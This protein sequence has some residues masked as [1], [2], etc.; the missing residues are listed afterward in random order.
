[1]FGAAI[2][3]ILHGF[4]LALSLTGKGS[5]FPQP[6][7]KREEQDCFMRMW[8]GDRAARE[9]LIL[10]NMRLVTHIIHKYYTTQSDHE[11]LISIGTIGLVKAVDSYKANKNTAFPTYA[12]TCI[13]NEIFMV[14]RNARKHSVLMFPG[15]TVSAD[16][17]GPNVDVLDM[18]QDPFDVQ[19]ALEKDEDCRRVRELVEARLDERAR[20]IIRLR[21]G[22]GGSAPM[23]QREVAARLNISRSYVSRIEK[24]ALEELGQFM[25]TEDS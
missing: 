19:L 11:D 1:M 18:A 4:A 12:C 25:M 24:R 22:I 8:A 10:H 5:V 7:S 3:L 14:F 20:E 9:K 16:G 13:K 6:L 23:T 15:R 17:E 2:T 21:Y